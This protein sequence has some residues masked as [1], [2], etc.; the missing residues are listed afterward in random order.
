MINFKNKVALVT[1]ASSGIGAAIAKKLSNQ[2]AR[3]FAAQRSSSDY[4]DMLSDLSDP[5][6]PE[7]IISVIKKVTGRLD[8]LINNAG[9]MTEGNVEET[10]L[11]NWNQHLAINLTAPFLLIK[12]AMPLLRKVRGSIVN[13]GSIEGLGNNPRHPAYG[14]SKSGLHGLTRA[15]AV[16]HGKDGVRCNAVAPGWIDTPLNEDFINSLDNPE[17]FNEKLGYI[18]P[19]GR[20]GK[21]SEVAELI[22]WLASDSASFVTGQVWTIDGGR[23]SKLSLP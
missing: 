5:K 8:I 3:V 16:D 20:S 7:E 12:Y 21:P 2:G 23:M 13:V 18:H 22:C 14:S 19:V 9:I 6:A 4:E 17:E 11:K 10:T 15:V 1:G